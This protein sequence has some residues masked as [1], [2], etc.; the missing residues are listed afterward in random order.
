MSAM[1]WELVAARIVL[2]RRA[3]L[4][5]RV[6]RCLTPAHRRMGDKRFDLDL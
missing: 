5:G 2:S 1:E 4:A 6:T 3:G